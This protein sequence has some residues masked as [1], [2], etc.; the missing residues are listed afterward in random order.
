[1][2]FIFDERCNLKESTEMAGSEK[3]ASIAL[4]YTP[5][6]KI[7]FMTDQVDNKEIAFTYWKYGK[8]ESITLKDAGTLLVKYTDFGDIERVDTIPHGKASERLKA[9]SNSERQS[10]I[11]NEVRSALD[12][13]LNYLRPAGLNIGL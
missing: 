6:G 10:T 13:M 7:A 3:R 4:K 8:P 2:T 11:L 5:Q 12:K 9:L 1:M